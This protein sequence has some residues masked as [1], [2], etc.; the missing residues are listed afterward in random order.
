MLYKINSISS[1]SR[2]A[3][4]FLA[5]AP[6]AS[7]STA[8]NSLVSMLIP[9]WVPGIFLPWRTSGPPVPVLK[10]M[11]LGMPYKQ[12]IERTTARKLIVRTK[13]FLAYMALLSEIYLP[14]L[15]HVNVLANRSRLTS[16][17]PINPGLSD[18]KKRSKISEL[19]RDIASL[20]S[21]GFYNLVLD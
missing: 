12:V 14:N 11:P 19:P 4:L 9:L 21:R 7:S 10:L 2:W 18:T 3:T 17:F 13:L 6:R 5:N 1:C 15:Y 20:W 16:I 8:M